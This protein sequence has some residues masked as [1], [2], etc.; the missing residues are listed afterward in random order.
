MSDTVVS[1]ISTQAA[2]ASP[3]ISV[4]RMDPRTQL[5][6]GC[7]RTI[8]EIASWSRYSDSDK[9][10]VWLRIAERRGKA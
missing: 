9:R 8:D 10:A 5:C 2:V 7:A 6:E 1:S 4:C 3:C